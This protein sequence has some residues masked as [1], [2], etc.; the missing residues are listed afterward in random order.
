MR[1]VVV[2]VKDHKCKALRRG[3]AWDARFTAALHGSRHIIGAQ[4]I[5]VGG[6]EGGRQGR[7][8]FQHVSKGT[9]PNLKRMR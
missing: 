7:R 1:G 8:Q 4:E 5:F 6:R 3:G 9:S 2:G